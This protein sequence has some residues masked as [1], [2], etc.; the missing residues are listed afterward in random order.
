MTT[1]MSLQIVN[2][3]LRERIRQ[4]DKWGIQDHEDGIWL[5]ILGEEFGEVAKEVFEEDHLLRSRRSELREELVQVAAVAIAWI[6]ALD[7]L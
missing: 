1:T 4:D 2:D 3:V 6:E 7:R 5:A